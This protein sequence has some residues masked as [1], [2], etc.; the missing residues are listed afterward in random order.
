MAPARPL[1]H[2]DIAKLIGL[3]LMF[4]D[5]AGVYFF[6]QEIWLRGIGRGAAPVFLFLAGYAA[7]YRFKPSL[8]LVALAMS[9]SDYLLTGQVRTQNILYSIL[10]WRLLFDWMEKRGY[11]IKRPFEWYVASLA[12]L[13][14]IVVIQYGTLGLIFA[15]CG[16]MQ[17]RPEQYSAA[18]RQLFMRVSFA[19]YAVLEAWLSSFMLIPAVLTYISVY[20]AYRLLIS[21]DTQPV[22]TSLPASLA[23]A[24]KL[25]SRYSLYIYGLHLIVLE[26]LT[27][28]P[29]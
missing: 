27:G 3:L 1:N 28:M 5:H 18:Q 21:I 13:S 24:A 4:V 22:A 16:Y 17:R 7:S 14:S 20:A 10:L 23:T 8:L 19:T 2:W 9:L 6:P 11:T 25:I 15:V 26:W 12:L 29:F